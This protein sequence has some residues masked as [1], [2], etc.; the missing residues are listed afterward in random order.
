MAVM[1]WFGID[2]QVLR[3]K[4]RSQCV[5]IEPDEDNSMIHF[6]DPFR[7]KAKMAGLRFQAGLAMKGEQP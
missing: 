2:E 5:S 4:S 3:A 7:T 1:D 6:P